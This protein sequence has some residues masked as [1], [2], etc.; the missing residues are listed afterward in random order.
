MSDN[1]F[2]LPV[3]QQLTTHLSLCQ[4]DELPILV[5][6]HPDFRAAIALQGAHL[7]SWQ[8]V[9]QQ[10]VIWLSEKA[11]FKKGQAIRGGIP[12][13]WP[14]FGKIATPSH[15]FARNLPWQLTEYKEDNDVINIFFMLKD[16]ASTQ[17]LW[18]HSFRLV[19]HITISKNQLDIQLTSFGHFDFTSA[20]HTYLNIGNISQTTI[21]G[22]GKDYFDSLTNTQVKTDDEELTVHAEIDR[23]YNQPPAI[24]QVSDNS[25]QRKLIMT[26]YNHHDIVVWNPFDKAKQMIDMNVDSYKTMICVETA[27]ISHS[28]HATEDKPAVFGVTIRLENN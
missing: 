25:Q 28:L 5:I 20:L 4:L 15:G 24:T 22:L 7:L 11:L 2:C 26:H 9:D 17:A 13:C 8:P 18:P 23:I 12:I 27:C 1:F 19:N 16:D 21:Y 6:N 10:P 3:E 14:W